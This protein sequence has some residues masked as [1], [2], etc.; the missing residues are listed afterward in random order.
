MD[1]PGNGSNI[2]DLAQALTR[3]VDSSFTDF[4]QRECSSFTAGHT[5][6]SL[7]GLML[8]YRKWRFSSDFFLVRSSKSFMNW[9]KQFLQH[10]D[11]INGDYTSPYI[12]I[13]ESTGISFKQIDHFILR[14]YSRGGVRLY[15]R[16]I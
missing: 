5:T 12:L 15:F 11:V 9:S 7:S 8:F 14:T 1:L 16:A 13:D 3:R 2:H 4:G 10:T 6:C